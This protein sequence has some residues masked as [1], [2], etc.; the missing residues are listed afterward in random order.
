MEQ[1]SGMIRARLKGIECVKAE[2]SSQV[3]T[4]SVELDD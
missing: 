2:W 3:L 1:D 4:V